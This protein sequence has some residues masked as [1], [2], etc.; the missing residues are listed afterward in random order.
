MRSPLRLT[1]RIGLL[2]MTV[3]ACAG[4]LPAQAMRQAESL[5]ASFR[6]AAEQALPAVVAIRPA[7]PAADI[8]AALYVPPAAVPYVPPLVGQFL[9]RPRSEPATG[10]QARKEKR[11]GSA[12]PPARA[13]TRREKDSLHAVPGFQTHENRAS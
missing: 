8:I 1:R 3:L 7:G 6:R 13:E 2:L 10:F 11:I 9:G 4:S 12:T 5:S